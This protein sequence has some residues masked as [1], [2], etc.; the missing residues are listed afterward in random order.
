MSLNPTGVAAL[1]LSRSV[2][3]SSALRSDSRS[4][5]FQLLVFL[6]VGSRADPGRDLA[7]LSPDRQCLEGVPTELAVVAPNAVLQRVRDLGCRGVLPSETGTLRIV[8]M[9]QINP[10][11]VVVGLRWA[12]GV[13]G[14]LT[15]EVGGGTVG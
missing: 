4:E 8:G 7:V 3:D 6:D 1:M 11:P 2:S 10:V 9:D 13:V 14:A 5:S 12:A 15:I